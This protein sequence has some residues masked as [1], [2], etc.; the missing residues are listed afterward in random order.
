MTKNEIIELMA[1][2]ADIT[3]KA[4]DKALKSFLNAVSNTVAEGNKVSLIGFGTFGLKERKEKTGI[5]PKTGE[6]IKIS[7]AKV[8]YF[9]PS[10]KLKQ[11]A[12]L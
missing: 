8:P 6:I 5:H 1:H 2:E 10:S 12:N 4:A 7:A 9:K 11:K 3:L